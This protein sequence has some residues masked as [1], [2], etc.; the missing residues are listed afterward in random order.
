[1]LLMAVLVAVTLLKKRWSGIEIDTGLTKQKPSTPSSEDSGVVTE[2]T[3]DMQ[4]PGTV[5]SLEKDLQ[6]Q[7]VEII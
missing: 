1:M 2:E 6:L 3:V 5:D 4:S 7:T